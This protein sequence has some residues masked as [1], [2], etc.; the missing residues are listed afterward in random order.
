[1]AGWSKGGILHVRFNST[2]LS[3]TI[4]AL[5]TIMGRSAIGV[6]RVSGPATTNILKAL[7]LK[8]GVPRPRL[9]S[10]RKLYNPKDG[11]MLDEALTIFFQS[12][13]SY[14]GEDLAEL[15]VHG[16][17]AVIKS[18]LAAIRN[19]H[20]PQAPIRYAENGEFSK[21]AF[22]NGRFDLT[23]VEGIRELTDAETESQR[24]SAL[25]SMKGETRQLFHHWREEIVKNVALLT[26]VIDFGEDHDIEEVNDLFDTVEKNIN[27]LESE[28]NEYLNRVKRSEILLKGIKVILLGPPNA[29]KSSLLN[30]LADKEAA[31]VSDIEGTT[32]DTIDIPL[33]INGYKVLIGDTAGIRSLANVGKIEKEG[34]R[35]AKLKSVDGDLVL[36][37]LP[38][39]KSN[40]EQELI[41]HVNELKLKKPVLV[42][43]NKSDLIR[44]SQEIV[45]NYQKIFNLPASSFKIISCISGEGITELISSLTQFFKKITVTEST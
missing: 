16:G 6:I 32:R 18:V 7:T 8:K 24:I 17:T 20:T 22:Q 28:I 11:V 1:M 45:E 37:V 9:A 42:I 2:Y 41:E 25:S 38:L 36:V 23:E 19:L 35:R 4:Y 10:V 39:D 31:I 27:K 13:K 30:Y 15:H 3:P 5:S 43:L 12:P 33:D 26:T 21:R 40:V 34:I 14:T 29:G 44:N